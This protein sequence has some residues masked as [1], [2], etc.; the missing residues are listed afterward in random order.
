VSAPTDNRENP[1]GPTHRDLCK[2]AAGWLLSSTGRNLHAAVDELSFDGGVAD[3]LGI[4]TP[5]PCAETELRA[6]TFASLAAWRDK[7]RLK[8][9]N[10]H[11]KRQ[12]MP[13]QIPP[14]EGWAVTTEHPGWTPWLDRYR[15][16][17]AKRLSGAGQIVVVECKR[18]RSD[19]LAD[20]RAGKLRRYEA[21]AT[22]CYLLAT[23]PALGIDAYMGLTDAERD[24]AAPGLPGEWGILT[25]S[26]RGGVYPIR[27][28]ERIREP[29][30][31]EIQA[32][33]DRMLAS[34]TFRAARA[35]D[36]ERKGE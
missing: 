24:H 32:W 6:R 28:A 4:S 34:Y 8:R 21:A 2:L 16:E 12:G 17:K 14:P 18:T 9:A 3:A 7:Q 23:M 30:E 22:E 33:A 36:R 27:N 35:Y 15:Q 31:W 19:L 11:L 13:P 5:N 20:L 26:P 10:A 1:A 25:V 29:D